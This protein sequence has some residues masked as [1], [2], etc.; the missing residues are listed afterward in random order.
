MKLE[1]YDAK[2]LLVEDN[3]I[4]RE[5]V[6][7]IM[8][9]LNMEIDVAES[10]VEAVEK[11]LANQY[12]IVFMDYL[13]PEMNGDEATVVVRQM[14]DERI[15]SLPIIAL[16]ASN[17]EHEKLIAAG[18]NDVMVKPINYDAITQI[19]VKWLPKG[20]VNTSEE[21]AP[22][23]ELEEELPQIEGI[24]AKRGV[25][26]CGSAKLLKKLF[27]DYCDV[28]EKKIELIKGF[29]NGK[30]LSQ[31][32]VEV[33]GLKSSS[34]LIGAIALSEEFAKLEKYSKEENLDELYANTPLVLDNYELLKNTLQE[35]TENDSTVQVFAS[36][37]RI[38][39][40]LDQ[41]D[42]AADCFN[43]DGVDEALEE[44]EQCRIPKCAQKEFEDLKT[45]VADVD[46]KNVMST[47]KR[48]SQM[49]M[50]EGNVR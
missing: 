22:K 15:K 41:M 46:L 45:Y 8:E 5:V 32:R 23:A 7:S 24:D 36:F 33:H 25:A 20:M 10:G 11:I 13:M 31:Y 6:L 4:N 40:L 38:E 14:G 19:L 18:M 35:Y 44:L 50:S 21:A 26:N 48:M 2:I 17:D 49:I 30:N 39:I 42:K 28:V 29:L 43:L 16:T 34:N 47:A 3:E 12:N 1:S 9:S 27:K 37:D